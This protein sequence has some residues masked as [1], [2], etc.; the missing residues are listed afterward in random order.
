VT[1]WWGSWCTTANIVLVGL[2]LLLL[3][4][5]LGALGGF[6]VTTLV[7]LGNVGLNYAL[8]STQGWVLSRAC[9]VTAVGGLG[10]RFQPKEHSVLVLG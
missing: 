5:R 4:P 7:M 2:C 8:F 9:R 1:P 10:Q 3:L 6:V